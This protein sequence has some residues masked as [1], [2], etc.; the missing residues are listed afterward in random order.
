METER[1]AEGVL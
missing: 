1:F